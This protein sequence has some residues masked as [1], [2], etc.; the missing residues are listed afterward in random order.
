MK[1]FS[2]KDEALQRGACVSFST[3]GTAKLENATETE[4]ITESVKQQVVSAL[5]NYTDIGVNTP[6]NSPYYYL[7]IFIYVS[8]YLRLLNIATFIHSIALYSQNEG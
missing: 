7:Y 5:K 3:T 6:M 4:I 8:L 1:R 2:D